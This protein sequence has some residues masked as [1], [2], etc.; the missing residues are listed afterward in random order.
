MPK[1][2]TL[3][4][5]H[6]LTCNTLFSPTRSWQLFC[7]DACREEAQ[8]EKRSTEYSCE[9][10][11]LVSD[12]I[13]HVP[14]RSV[15][16]T[17]IDL[18]LASKYP[19]VEVRACRECNSL[20]GSRPLWTIFLRRKF[21]FETLKKRYKIYLEMPDWSDSELEA[22]G[23]T[24]KESV[25]NGLAVRELTKK[26]LEVASNHSVSPAF[27]K[28]F[29]KDAKR[30]IREKN[31]TKAFTKIDWSDSDDSNLK[32]LKQCLESETVSCK[33]CKTSLS[34][35]ETN[36]AWLDEENQIAQCFECLEKTFLNKLV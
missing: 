6:C 29:S 4:G 24:L 20:L 8:R 31:I 9:Y 23:Y 1:R 36:W 14:P 34:I 7:K 11:G 13:D 5:R 2:K 3:P 12:S 32:I 18:G 21:I 25:L 17:L 35:D 22:L 30:L 16:S 15:R 26:R 28:E 33:S 10:C 27:Q 19:F